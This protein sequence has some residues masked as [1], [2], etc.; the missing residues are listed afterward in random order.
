MS[1][2]ARNISTPENCLPFSSVANELF[3]ITVDCFMI[4]VNILGKVGGRKDL[5][6]DF[7]KHPCLFQNYEAGSG[8]ELA[9]VPPFIFKFIHK[10]ALN[11]FD[12]LIPLLFFTVFM[13]TLLGPTT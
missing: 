10:E 3:A 4:A 6:D 11:W 12:L 7:P 1:T 5:S 8:L 2:N 13:K 9:P